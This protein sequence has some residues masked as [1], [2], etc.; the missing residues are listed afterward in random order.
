[1]RNCRGKMRKKFTV[2]KNEDEEKIKNK[3]GSQKMSIVYGYLC[4]KKC[5][6]VSGK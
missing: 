4:I 1:M 3:I 2:G 5:C 6:K